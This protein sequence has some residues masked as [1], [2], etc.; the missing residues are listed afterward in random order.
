MRIKEIIK[1]YRKRIIKKRKGK[2]SRTKKKKKENDVE[3]AHAEVKK[4]ALSRPTPTLGFGSTGPPGLGFSSALSRSTP[5]LNTKAL[6]RA[7]PTFGPRTSSIQPT[8]L[9][10]RQ[11]NKRRF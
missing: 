2:R 10:R 9:S 6:S 11:M 5:S 3:S 7:T 8:A 1:E 4:M